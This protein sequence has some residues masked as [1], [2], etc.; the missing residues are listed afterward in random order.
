MNVS[1]LTDKELDNELGEIFDEWD[2]SNKVF[3]LRDLI[4]IIEEQSRREY[5]GI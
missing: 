3:S 4:E 5:N 2:K 1:K